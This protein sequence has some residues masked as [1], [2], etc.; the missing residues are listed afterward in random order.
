MTRH[1]R[2]KMTLKRLEEQYVNCRDMDLSLPSATREAVAE[3]VIR[4][5][6]TCYDCL[7]KTLKLYLTECFG[8]ADIPNS[9]K[10]V[11][12][13]A[14]ENNLFAG[15]LEQWMVYADSRVGIMDDYERQKLNECLEIVGD[16]VR[17]AENL[18][19]TI[20]KETYD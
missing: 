9:P 12:R 17:D 4:R 18:R 1:E 14:F 19:K 10:P 16:F 5:F 20:G 2:F 8:V 11:F 7:W 13:L 15:S 6:N 3:S